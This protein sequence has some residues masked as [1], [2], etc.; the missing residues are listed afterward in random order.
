MR[1]TRTWLNF[2]ECTVSLL[3]S[4]FK[5]LQTLQAFGIV[6]EISKC[7]SILCKLWIFVS[8]NFALQGLFDY[9]HQFDTKKYTLENC[10]CRKIIFGNFLIIKHLRISVLGNLYA[11][12]GAAKPNP[13]YF[14]CSIYN[15]IYNGYFFLML[16]KNHF[17]PSLAW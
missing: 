9:L 11:I 17:T 16:A 12:N 10:K 1:L 7:N 13:L 5:I 2:K 14:T 15:Y 8:E 3:T 6:L 4:K